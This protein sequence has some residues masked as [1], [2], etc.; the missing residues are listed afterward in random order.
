MASVSDAEVQGEWVE[1]WWEWAKLRSRL[2][3]LRSRLS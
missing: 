3:Y 1:S 2:D